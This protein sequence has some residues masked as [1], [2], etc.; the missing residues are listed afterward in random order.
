MN[1][2]KLN[3]FYRNL[4]RDKLISIINA[5]GLII[6]ILSA[7]FILEYVYYQRSYDNHHENAKDIYRVAYNRYQNNEVLWKTANSFPPTG[8]WLKE[9]YSDV[10]NHARITPKNEI[11]IS[12][13]NASGSKIIYSEDKTYYATSSLFEVFTIPLLQGEKDPLKAPNTVAISHLAAER[14]FGEERPLG[15]TIKVNGNEDYMITAVY[16]KMPK[17]SIVKSDFL[18]SMETIYKQRSRI[19]TSWTYDYGSTFIQL[20]PNSDYKKLEKEG[21]PEMIA[22]NYKK[23]LDSQGKRDTYYLQPLQDIHLTSNIEY[24]SEP[25]VNGKIISILFGFSIFLLI[26]AWINFINLTTARSIERANE[27]G[28]KKINGAS[29]MNLI[30]QFLSEA[31]LFNILCLAITIVLFYALNP[32][33]KTITQIGDFNLFEH[34]K[35]LGTFIVIFVLGIIISCIYPAVILQSYKPV[36]VL[37]GKFKNKREGVFFRKLLVTLQFVISVVLLCGTLIAYKQATFLM[38]KDMGINY[39]QS[40]VIKAPKTGEKQSE[41][42]SKILLMK[43]ELTQIPEVKGFTF[44]SDIPGQEIQHWFGCRRKGYDHTDSNGYFQLSVD[45][46]FLEFYNV[47]LLAGRLFRKGEKETGTK[48]IIM[49]VKAMERVGYKT[50]EEAINNFVVTGRNEEFKIIGIVD[51][52]YYQS[53]KNEPVPTVLRLTDSHKAFLILKV[54]SNNT[55]EILQK[56]KTIYENYFPEQPFDYLSLENKISNTLKSDRTFLFVFSLFSILA[57]IIAVIGIV[58]L[59]LITISQRM[60]EIG[61]RKVLGSE[62]MDVSKLLA[63]EV[64]SQIIIAIIIAIPLAWYG[65]QNWFLK[66]YINSIELQIW[67]FLVPVIVLFIIVFLVIHLVALRAYQMTLSEVLQNE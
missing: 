7:L 26:I 41:L 48:S 46:Q 6:G 65:Y 2:I 45:D 12:Y 18:F 58:G 39:A 59:I 17:N 35:F 5:V 11:T 19:R 31:F 20:K 25:P 51:D 50:P 21:L 4:K 57:I 8:K 56:L 43:D 63:K 14:Y 30:T 67:M 27:V 29:K 13:N 15:K 34:S 62:L 36:T 55:T 9:H 1:F 16:K 47:K 49:N 24:E 52:F 64:A 32:W 10:V 61:I 44:S 54:A 66:T 60:K 53:I 28:V 37:K 42:Q 40:I 33:F 22:A 38:E 3:I 23:R